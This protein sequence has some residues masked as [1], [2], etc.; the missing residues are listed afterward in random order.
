MP[1]GTIA[2]KCYQND[3][4]CLIYHYPFVLT[5]KETYL[6]IKTFPGVFTERNVFLDEL[7]KK[8]QKL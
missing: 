1:F 5:D 3:L 2:A 4:D 7:Q 8:L 6:K